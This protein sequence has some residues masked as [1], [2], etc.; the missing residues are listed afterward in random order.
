[1]PRLFIPPVG[2]VLGVYARMAAESGVWRA[3]AGDDA[4]VNLALGVEFPMTDADLTDLVENGSVNGIRAVPGSGIVIDSS[5]TL[6][7]DT[8]WRYVNVRRLFNFVKASLRDSLRFVAQEPH[9]DGLRRRVKFNVVMPFLLGLWSQGAF[10]SD[11]EEQV[12]TIKCDATN[13]PP[14]QVQQGFFTLEVYFYPVKPAEKII[15]T[16]AQ[17]PSGATASEA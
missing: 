6:S 12:F 16:V 17:Q 15:I 5:R 10:G 14:A 11:P 13:N 3:P 2:H 8:R 4:V 1:V 9:D 7:T